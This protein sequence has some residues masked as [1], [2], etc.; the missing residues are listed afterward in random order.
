MFMSSISKAAHDW[1][2]RYWKVMACTAATMPSTMETAQMVNSGK[3][4]LR[5]WLQE[6]AGKTMAITS[7]NKIWPERQN[8]ASIVASVCGRGWVDLCCMICA[9]HK[10]ISP[11]YQNWHG[12]SA[13]RNLCEIFV[14]MPEELE[15]IVYDKRLHTPKIMISDLRFFT[16]LHFSCYRTFLLTR[17]LEHLT[18]HQT[19]N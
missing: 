6:P 19:I 1:S 2:A 4:S 15:E 5:T 10:T 13:E 11:L 8:N 18:G 16:T 7:H 17:Q 14:V 9:L 12:N 3:T